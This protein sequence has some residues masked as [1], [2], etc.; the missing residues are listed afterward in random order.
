MK[1]ILVGKNLEDIRPMLL[2]KTDKG[3]FIRSL[4]GQNGLRKRI[5]ILSISQ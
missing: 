1:I 5:Y 2:H 3:G 4:Y